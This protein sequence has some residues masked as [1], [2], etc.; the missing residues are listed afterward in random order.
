MTSALFSIVVLLLA[1]VIAVMAF[2]R[3]RLPP[4]LAYLLVGMTIGPFALG[5]MPNDET[6]QHL[7]EF[8]IVFLM[9]S[10]GLEFSLAQ[11][12]AMR[13]IVFGLGGAQVILTIIVVM[14]I[15][16]AI[17]IDWRGGLT[18]GGIIAMSSTAIVAKLLME[19]V[20]LQSA[21]GRLVMGVLLFQDLAVVPLLVLLPA[22]AQEPERFL[23]TF[24]V[25]MLKAVLILSLLLWYGRRVMR[26]F[27]HLVAKQKSSEIFVLNVLF[28]TLGLAWVTEIAGLSM[29][30]GAFVDA[31]IGGVALKAAIVPPR[32]FPCERCKRSAIRNRPASQNAGAI[33]VTPNGKPLPRNPPGSATALRSSKF[34]KFV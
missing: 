14:A 20:E 9:F 19:R 25:A 3:F 10:I 32:C 31:T 18:V 2:R 24:G 1:V 8:G 28:V 23:P 5:W 11:L 34:T 16:M 13:R 21:H 7:A 17:G 15:A 12:S 4:M 22:L 33:S 27:F 26:S 30:L 29:A 6:T